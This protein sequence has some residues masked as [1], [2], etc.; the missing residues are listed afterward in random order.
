ML[1]V[2]EQCL[3]TILYMICILCL[4]V[5]TR[6]MSKLIRAC[7]CKTFFPVHFWSLPLLSDHVRHLWRRCHIGDRIY[8]PFAVFCSNQYSIV[9]LVCDQS[10]YCTA[11]ST[12]HWLALFRLASH[13]ALR[14][15]PFLAGSARDQVTCNS[16]LTFS[17]ILYV[18]VLLY[19]TLFTQTFSFDA[20]FP[21]VVLHGF[22]RHNRHLHA[23]TP[24]SNT[25]FLALLSTWMSNSRPFC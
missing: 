11:F 17:S 8:L 1:H 13:A 6:T 12:K 4:L 15:G 14:M 2:C 20:K 7:S 5:I 25:D 21:F 19:I 18:F 23:V 3:L 10:A 9:N 22:C 16:F 24:T